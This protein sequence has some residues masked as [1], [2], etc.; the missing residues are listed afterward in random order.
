M[1]T[2]KLN[3]KDMIN[4]GIFAAILAV[5]KIVSGFIG[6]VPIICVILP[7][8]T[9]I[10]SGPVY[11]LFFS[12]VSKFGMITILTT[13]LGIIYCVV[14]YG[15][16]T[17]VGSFIIGFLA[18]LVTKAGGYNSKKFF[19]MG[20]CVFALWPITTYI[21]IWMSGDAYFEELAKSMGQEFADGFQKLLPLWSVFP[22]IGLTLIAG[23]IGAFIGTKMMKKH[24]ERI[25]A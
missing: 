2:N 17:L 18:D 6:V 3:V 24:F 9:A 19:V 16:Q 10:I 7:A 15:W 13:I 11:A 20:Y 22:L 23:C 1:E 25:G 4:V 12:K 21:M 8:I 14:G 5:L